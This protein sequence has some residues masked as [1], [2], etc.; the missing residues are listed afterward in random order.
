M[1]D[2]ELSEILQEWKA[3]GAPPTLRNRVLPQ[4]RSW[5]RWLLTGTIRV[6]VPVGVAA[7]VVLAFWI[8]SRIPGTPLQAPPVPPT[9]PVTLADFQPVARLAP[10]I[11][12]EQ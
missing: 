11:V 10:R 9:P 5:W 4:E 3:P 8:Y 12:G 1:D 2:P 6:P 7:I